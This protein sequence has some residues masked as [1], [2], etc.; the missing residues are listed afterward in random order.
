MD[1]LS[2]SGLGTSIFVLNTPV[3]RVETENDDALVAFALGRDGQKAAKFTMELVIFRVEARRT[4][5]VIITCRSTGKF[6]QAGLRMNRMVLPVTISRGNEKI[7]WHVLTDPL[8]ELVPLVRK[9]LIGMIVEFVTNT[10]RPDYWSGT[11]KDFPVG[12]T[13]K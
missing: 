11:N 12:V 9:A 8:A 1:V 10:V 2:T 4:P 3:D 6:V 7:I 13:G 5:G